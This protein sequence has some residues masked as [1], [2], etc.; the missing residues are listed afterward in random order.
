MSEYQADWFLDEE[1]HFDGDA[2]HGQT[3]E[4]ATDGEVEPSAWRGDEEEDED[5]A[6]TIL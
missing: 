3:H 6:G 2:A 5:M 1:G 4:A